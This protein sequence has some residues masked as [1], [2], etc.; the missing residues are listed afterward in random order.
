TVLV[1]TLYPLLLVMLTGDKISVGPP[2]FNSTFLPLA[3]PLL[4]IVPFGQTLAWKRGDALAA[5]QR[6]F[7]ALGPALA[8]GLAA[9][10][11]TW[12]GP[13]LAPVG[14]GLGAYLII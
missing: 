7:F 1:G 13:V 5:A 9:L 12:G 10:A 11:L 2:F 14:I 6:L 4:L 3:V 8:V